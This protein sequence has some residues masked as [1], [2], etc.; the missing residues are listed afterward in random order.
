MK[1]FK[2]KLYNYNELSDEVRKKL[3]EKNRWNLGD[4]AMEQNSDERRET[5]KKFE[6]LFGI[7]VSYDVDYCSSW[8]KVCFD[9]A[10]YESN[11]NDEKEW[12]FEAKDV[13]GRLLLRFLNSKSYAF[14]EWKSYW[15]DFK[16]DENGKSLTKKRYS[17][18]I[19]ISECPLTGVCYDEDILYPIREFLKKPDMNLSLQDL[20]ERCVEEFVDLWHKEWEY[21]CDD[22][23]FLDEEMEH[24]HEGDLFLYDGT[25]F[26]GNIDDLEEYFAA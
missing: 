13:K 22:N 1:E 26:T 14:S 21:C 24:R 11:W 12:Y 6:E 10:I 25:E 18:I 20:I 19:R 5:L 4:D 8:C 23:N 9:S 15:G 3:I 16:W 7:S 17:K 2:I